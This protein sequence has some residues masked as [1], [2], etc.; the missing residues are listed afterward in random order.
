MCVCLTVFNSFERSN[1]L[2]PTQLKW[3]IVGR[4]IHLYSLGHEEPKYTAFYS[5]SLTPSWCFKI[6]IFDPVTNPLAPTLPPHQ[7]LPEKQPLGDVLTTVTY[8]K[9]EEILANIE[10]QLRKY[11]KHLHW[12]NITAKVLLFISILQKIS[13][14][15]LVNYK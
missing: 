2:L 11:F 15:I 6:D 5:S 13:V 7:S 3:R 14:H 8:Q 12:L 10:I 4:L 1:D 9:W